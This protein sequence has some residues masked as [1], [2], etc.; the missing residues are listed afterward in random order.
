MVL[1][2][3]EPN[4]LNNYIKMILM[5]KDINKISNNQKSNN[6]Q[7]N[8]DEIIKNQ[9]SSA[10]IDSF[11][12]QHQIQSIPMFILYLSETDS[13]VNLTGKMSISLQL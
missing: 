4:L 8:I 11:L 9:M 10:I 3:L 7:T 6:D 2:L 12:N 1:I 5:L 13:P